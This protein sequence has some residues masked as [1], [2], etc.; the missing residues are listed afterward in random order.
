[1]TYQFKIL[2]PGS[3]NPEIWRR[4]LVPSNYSFLQFHKVIR[5]AFNKD[6]SK[7]LLFTFSPAGKNS[8]PRIVP[9]DIAFEDAIGAELTVLSSMFKSQGQTYTYQPDVSD[10]WQHLIILEKMIKDEIP[11]ADCLD[12]EGAYPPVTCADFDDY[13]EMK[14]ILSDKNHPQYEF[15]HEWLE[16]GENETY[17]EAHDFNLSMIKEQM[18]HIDSEIKSFR[19]Y[20][21]V[22]Y[23]T[24]DEKYGLTPY[25]WKLI[26]KLKAKMGKNYNIPETIH[27]IE[28][29]ISKYPQIPHFKNSLA[30]ANLDNN[31][32]KRY[33]EILQQTFAEY[34][35]YVLARSSLALQYA[36]DN[37]P[38][39]A[40]ELLGKEFDLSVLYPQRK[41]NFTEIEICSYHIVVFRNLLLSG[42]YIDAEKHLDFLTYL[43]PEE[44][45]KST[46]RIELGMTRL[47]N[48][49]KASKS[50]KVIPE[51]LESTSNAPTFEHPEIDLL[52]QKDAYIERATLEKIMALPR[53]SLIRD[54][55]KI[56]ID[57]ITRFRYF[58]K[59]T[60][61]AIPDAPI[62]ALNLLS[63]LEAFEA[64]E[65]ILKILRQDK[66]YYD[67]WYG[68]LL[69]E[70]FWRFIYMTGQHRLDRLKDLIL[71][72]NRYTYVR[73]AVSEA[74][75]HIAFHQPNRKEET[76]KWYE[77]VLQY[78]QNN[79]KKTAIFEEDVYS[80]LVDDLIDLL[81]KEQFPLVKRFCSFKLNYD[82]DFSVEKVKRRLAK[83]APD[84]KI[85]NIHTS[86]HQYYDVWKRWVDKSEGK[87]SISN[88]FRPSLDSLLAPQNA[89]PQTPKVGRNDPCPCGSGKKYKKCCG[90]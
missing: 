7:Q 32:K 68:V 25:L 14:Q 64:L 51:K 30:L 56:L 84:Y 28:T 2:L 70:E 18:K 50:V 23:Y 17:E 9:M 22:E 63:A 61:L 38:I 59:N 67:L 1:M 76:L 44:F 75:K 40:F 31:N 82:H 83:K 39:K 55:E 21:I 72:P 53:E 58:E 24:F 79:K 41:G 73:T 4:V 66:K 62:H 49:V 12:G 87:S 34:P 35:D 13:E 26:D 74:V 33:F 29:L 54:L 52:Y 11:C 19:N 8:I 71:E 47:K 65:T 57:S 48:Q 43:F 10:N 42:N 80:A 81:E 5:T 69:T 86:I 46:F 45:Q 88:S 78:L 27:E 85:H 60:D 36:I 77:D 90:G 89:A 37:Q 20:T 6:Y 16:L 3:K 15:I